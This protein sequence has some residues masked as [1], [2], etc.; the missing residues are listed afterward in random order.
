MQHPDPSEHRQRIRIGLTGL[1][2][3]F[4]LVMLGTAVSRSGTTPSRDRRKQM[5]WPIARSPR[6]PGADRSRPG[7]S[8]TPNEVSEQAPAP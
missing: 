1:A 3:V 2:F 5:G 4:L 7:Q 6:N 8:T